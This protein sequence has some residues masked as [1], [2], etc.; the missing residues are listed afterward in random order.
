MCNRDC[1]CKGK[2][3]KCCKRL[4]HVKRCPTETKTFCCCG[5][6]KLTVTIHKPAKK[7]RVHRDKPECKKEAGCCRPCCAKLPLPCDRFSCGYNFK[8][9]YINDN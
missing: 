5:E 1:K 7:F 2:K 4:H 6:P 3:G 9:D 8:L